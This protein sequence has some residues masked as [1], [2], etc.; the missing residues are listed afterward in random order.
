[1]SSTIPMGIAEVVGIQ[2]EHQAGPLLGLWVG[3]EAEMDVEHR[4]FWILEE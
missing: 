2:Q 1:M 3:R 4:G